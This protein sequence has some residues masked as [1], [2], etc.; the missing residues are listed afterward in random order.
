[1]LEYLGRRTGQPRTLVAAYV[2]TGSRVVITVGWPERKTWWRNFQTPYGVRVRL[3]GVEH[4]A[5]AHVERVGAEVRLLVD[6]DVPLVPAPHRSR[7]RWG[8]PS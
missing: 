6:L 1:V 3:A 4:D 5:T 8:R 7:A 2:R